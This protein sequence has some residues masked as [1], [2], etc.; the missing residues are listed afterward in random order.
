MEWRDIVDFLYLWYNEFIDWYSVQPIYGQILVIVGIIAILA[1]AIT[2]V[3][4]M[5][6][7]IVYLIYYILKGIS[8]LLKW[9]GLGLFKLG[10]GFYYLVSGEERPKKQTQDDNLNT[11]VEV[12]NTILY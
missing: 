9:I 4:Y 5:I 6:K 11:N 2:L 7:G 12:D 1:L 8:S 3:Y 10:E